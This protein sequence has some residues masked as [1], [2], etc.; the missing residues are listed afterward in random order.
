VLSVGSVDLTHLVQFFKRVFARSTQL[1]NST[2]LIMAGFVAGLPSALA[3]LLE[4][5][6]QGAISW[7]Q[8]I[9]SLALML[10]VVAAIVFIECAQRRLLVQYAR[11]QMGNRMFPG[12]RLAS[13]LEAQRLRRHCAN[14]LPPRCC[15][16]R[17]P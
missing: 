1:V 4:L 12:R 8:L 13:A 5:S 3:R 14:H 7:L 11:Q 16:C 6:R 2:S 17:S 15:C 10:A 9:A